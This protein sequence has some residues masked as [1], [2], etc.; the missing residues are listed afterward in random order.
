MKT[1]DQWF[2]CLT[3]DD[4]SDNLFDGSPTGTTKEQ[5][6]AIDQLFDRYNTEI[7]QSYGLEFPDYP[8]GV[9]EI[10]PIINLK[11]FCDFEIMMKLANQEYNEKEYNVFKF[12]NIEGA[13]YMISGYDQ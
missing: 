7:R 11:E 13:N 6:P 2:F 3:S 4:D 1:N 10:E 9:V 8:G 5:R 12:L